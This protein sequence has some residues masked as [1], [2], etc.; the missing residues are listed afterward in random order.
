MTTLLE[1]VQRMLYVPAGNSVG[2]VTLIIF[3]VRLLDEEVYLHKNKQTNKHTMY[4]YLL[5]K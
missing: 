3:E 5:L 2:A 1:N 4:F